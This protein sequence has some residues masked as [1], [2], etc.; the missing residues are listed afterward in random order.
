MEIVCFYFLTLYSVTEV[1]I[2]FNQ[3]KK[4]HIFACDD[5]NVK[6]RDLITW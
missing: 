3:L 4:N 6:K 1:N 2:L 5:L